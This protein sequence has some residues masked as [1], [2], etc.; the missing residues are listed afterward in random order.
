MGRIITYQIFWLIAV[1]CLLIAHYIV[2]TPSWYSNNIIFAQ[3]TYFGCLGG[4]LYCLRAIY[5]NKSVYK[6]WDT[7]WHVWYYLRPV[8]SSISG[9]V[10]CIF[11]KAGLLVLEASTKVDETPYGYLAIAFIAGYNVDNFMKKLESVAQTVWGITKSKASSEA[12]SSGE[13]EKADG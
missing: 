2:K 8:T 6:R 5:I 9:L 12:E 4:V 11:L 13:G 1:F 7:D 3:C 10:S